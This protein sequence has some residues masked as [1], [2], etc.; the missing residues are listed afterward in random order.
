MKLHRWDIGFAIALGF[1]LSG[2][3]T[4]T[5]TTVPDQIVSSLDKAVETGLF[6]PIGGV[7]SVRY[8]VGTWPSEDQ[9]LPTT[10]TVLR[11]SL[12][13]TSQAK[14]SKA[15]IVVADLR[16]TAPISRLLR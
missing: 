6:P 5:L 3:A 15:A 13:A 2:C 10:A 1:A 11:S 9:R 7:A 4:K 16:G 8:R 14:A 12:K